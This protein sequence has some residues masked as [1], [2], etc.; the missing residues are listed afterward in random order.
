[1]YSKMADG[2]RTAAIL[3]FEIQLVSLDIFVPMALRKFHAKGDI[4]IMI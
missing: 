4:C 2:C 1:M 3:D